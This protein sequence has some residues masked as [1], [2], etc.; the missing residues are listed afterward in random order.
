MNKNIKLDSYK[1]VLSFILSERLITIT[2]IGSIVTFQFVGTFKTDIVD[3]L[4]EFMLP[5]EN[6]GFMNITIRD[7]IEMNTPSPKK[8]KMKFGNFF[9]EFI[10]WIFVI[11]ILFLLAKYSRFPDDGFNPGVA[12]M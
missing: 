7:G 3:P 10:K 4:L 8:L 6:F 12:I 1:N 9:K 2:V 5:E 11:T